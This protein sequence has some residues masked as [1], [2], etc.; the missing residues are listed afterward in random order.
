[1]A[2]RRIIQPSF[3]GGELDEKLLGRVDK[4]LYH[5]G[6]QK[7]K[8]VLAIVQGGL[9]KR[10]G[11][12]YISDIAEGNK[13]LIRFEFSTTQ[14]YLMTLSAGKLE[15]RRDDVL[16]TNINGSGNNFLVLPYG[17]NDIDNIDVLQS[18]DTLFLFHPNYPMRTVTRGSSHNLW[19]TSTDLGG[20]QAT[21]DFGDIKYGSFTFSCTG[22]GNF[23]SQ[24]LTSSSAA[25]T[26][27]HV[28]GEVRT[29]SG[30][31][32][33]TAFGSGTSVTIN[34]VKDLDDTVSTGTATFGGDVII[35]EEPAFSASRGYPTCGVFHQGRLWLG[36]SGDTLQTMFGSASDLFFNFELGEG[37]ADEAIKFTL[38]TNQVNSITHLVSSS[39]LHIFTTGGTFY[40]K[41]ADNGPITPVD[42]SPTLN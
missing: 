29:A 10:Q 31:A 22:G 17:E 7:A 21:H 27:A 4:D 32:R 37:L 11:T 6:V 16:E 42:F 24:T 28:G 1:M 18:L 35:V 25:F 39:H 12:Q 34:V 13:R 33:I 41:T 30:F 9:L 8:N 20:I 2:E 14:G 15:I 23:G 26:S 5:T 38:N 36:G 19:N 3:S 40:V